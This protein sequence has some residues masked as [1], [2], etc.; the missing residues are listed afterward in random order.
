MSAITFELPLTSIPD[1]HLREGT[2]FRGIFKSGKLHVTVE[3]EEPKPAPQPAM[4]EREAA[5]RNYIEK[6]SGAFSMP[7]KEE[8]A[9][10]PRLDYLIKKHVLCIPSDEIF[11]DE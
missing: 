9:A 4:S 5:A 11:A 1:I 3:S 10:D 7:T 2:P 8:L 6:W